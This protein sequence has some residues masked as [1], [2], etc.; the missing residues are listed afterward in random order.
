M[1]RELSTEQID[2]LF[3]F[4]KRKYVDFYDIQVEIVD[5]LASAIEAEYEKSNDIS[6]ETALT[7]VYSSF[8]IFGFSDVQ[9]QKATAVWK[10][11]STLWYKTFANQFRWPAIVKVL[12]VWLIIYTVSSNFSTI[13]VNVTIA[14]FLALTS[15][16]FLGKE[17]FYIKKNVVKKLALLQQRFTYLSM[18]YLPI[19]LYRF[20]GVWLDQQ[21]PWFISSFFTLL[22]LMIFTYRETSV[23]VINEAKELYPEAFKSFAAN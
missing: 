5:H 19:Y 21:S 6:F 10:K 17:S 7:N 15:L 20:F 13:A 8:G 23:R 1:K 2:Q 18:C 11:N 22:A 4:T 9:E 14:I 3:D 12:I 16:Y